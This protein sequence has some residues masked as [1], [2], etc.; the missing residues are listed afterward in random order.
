MEL[1]KDTIEGLINILNTNIVT[2]DNFLQIVEM[3]ILYIYDNPTEIKC[4]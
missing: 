4:K 1:P 3:A 2:D